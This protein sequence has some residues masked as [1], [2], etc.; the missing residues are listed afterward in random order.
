MQAPDCYYLVFVVD[1]A[2]VPVQMSSSPPGSLSDTASKALSPHCALP[3]SP[4]DSEYQ[5]M[6]HCCLLVHK[7]PCPVIAMLQTS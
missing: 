5:H 3:L 6:S 4:S 2:V 1:G 7:L